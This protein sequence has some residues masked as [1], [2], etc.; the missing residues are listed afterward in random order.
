MTMLNDSAF[1]FKRKQFSC[2]WLQMRQISIAEIQEEVE[3]EED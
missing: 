2:G 3:S 1:L